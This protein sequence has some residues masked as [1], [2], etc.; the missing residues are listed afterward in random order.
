MKK[1]FVL[2]ACLAFA[3]A[4]HAQSLLTK[5]N[6]YATNVRTGN[7]P[8]AGDWGLYIGP[9]YSEVMDLVD[10]FGNF[11][12]LDIVRGLPLVNIK[13][14]T[15]D[16]LEFRGG[17]QYYKR[18]FHAKGNEI[19]TP[20]TDKEHSMKESEWFFRLI[21]GFAY[22]FSPR[23][24]LDV[25]AGASLPLGFEGSTY[26]DE[27]ANPDAVNGVLN[28]YRKS[29]CVGLEAFIGLQAFIADLPVSVGF[30]Y[31]LSG[32]FHTGQK[33]KTEVYDAVN[34]TTQTTYQ[35]LGDPTDYKDLKANSGVFGSDLRLTITYYFNNK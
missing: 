2:M 4:L 24:V 10:C 9:S 8:G 25:Y 26:K 19:L 16:N 31:G 28:Q 35:L 34:N 33:V 11:T 29:L 17:I 27:Y 15:S 18:G 22:H 20:T 7:R 12:N 14:Y 32:M 6:P 23:N 3:G 21:P 30:E 13:Y 5:G 1:L